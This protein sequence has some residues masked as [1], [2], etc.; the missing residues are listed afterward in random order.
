[1]SQTL[2]HAI[3]DD[4]ME[5]HELGHAVVSRLE[6][7]LKGSTVEFAFPGIVTVQLRSG[8][9]ARCGGPGIGWIVDVMRPGA[10]TDTVDVD[11][12]VSETDPVVI[13]DA[14]AKALRRW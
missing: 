6:K 7:V 13:A 5:S 11:V 4:A 9:V 14:I 3:G 10:E 2:E 12:A 8:A 1:M